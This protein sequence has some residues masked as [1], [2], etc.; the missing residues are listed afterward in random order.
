MT[1]RRPR[2]WTQV[3]LAVAFAWGYDAVR[4]LHGDVRTAALHHAAWVVRIDHAMGVGW[5]ATLAQWVA[6]HDLVADVLCGYY[7]GMHFAMVCVTLIAL[8]VDG[9]F[10][11]WYRD[12]LLLASVIAF[13]VFWAY[14][15]APPRLLSP[16]YPDSVKLVLPFAY[17]AEAA[18]AN[19]YAAVPSLHVAWAVWCTIAL[20]TIVRRWW[21]RSL[22]LAH[23]LLTVLTV[24]AT[25][26]HYLFDVLTGVALMVV[27]VATLPVGVAVA[28]RLLPRLVVTAPWPFPR[29]P[30][31][32]PAAIVGP[33]SG[34]AG[35]APRRRLRAT[36]RGTPGT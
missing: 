29:V 6:A 36:V 10:Y 22:A 5:L 7:V 34:R 2:W 27:S 4:A 15:V 33:S 11:R 12:A 18:A 31:P 19:L 20:L 30:R 32:L 1:Q 8:W 28:G 3:I 16:V 13:V 21:L 14:P 26:N 9:R 25:G 23:T 17:H 24:M 35:A